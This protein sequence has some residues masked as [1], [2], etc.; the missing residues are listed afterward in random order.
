MK[1]KHQMFLERLLLTEIDISR[2]AISASRGGTRVLVIRQKGNEVIIVAVKNVK[3]REHGKLPTVLGMT[4]VYKEQGWWRLELMYADEP[5]AMI[6]LLFATLRLLKKVVSDKWVSPEA[7][8]ILKHYYDDMI[9]NKPQLVVKNANS[10]QPK[11][12]EDFLRAGYLD[13][14]GMNVNLM[15]EEG[16]KLLKQV[17]SEIPEL[18]T[19]AKVT[20]ALIETATTGFQEAYTDTKRSGITFDTMLDR[21][22]YSVLLVALEKALK[23]GGSDAKKVIKWYKEN[24]EAVND[25]VKKDQD[26]VDYW[27]EAVLPALWEMEALRHMIKNVIVEIIKRSPQG[28]DQSNP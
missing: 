12:A 16:K 1:L 15:I 10:N 24:Q 23:A 17:S 13:P 18:K 11:D 26:M 4:T 21:K 20:D 7:Q 5:A 27:K 19:P 2:L 28:I 6:L 3:D 9:K 14:G 25:F 8:K 22:Q